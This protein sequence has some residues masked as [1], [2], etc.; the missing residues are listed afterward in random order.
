MNLVEFLQEHRVKYDTNHRKHGRPGWTQLEECPRCYSRNYHLG[1]KNDCSRANCYKCG[2]FN[3]ARLLLDVTKA[4]WSE[5]KFLVGGRIYIPP[6]LDTGNAGVYTEPR[7]VCDLDSTHIAYLKQ[8][9]LDP[10]YCTKVWGIRGLGPWAEYPFR[11]FLPIYYQNRPVSWTSRATHGQEPRYQTAAPHQKSLDEKRILYGIDFI[12]ETTIVLEGPFD[13]LRVGPGA[14]GTLG[15]S[16][17]RAQFSIIA[18]IPR[19]ILVFDNSERAQKIADTLA[20][21]LSLFPGETIRVNLDAEDPGS[22]SDSEIYALRKFAF[23]EHYA[24]ICHNT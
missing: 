5:V 4:P 11:V 18:S 17:T 6:T 8:R 9:G 21:E 1:I 16:V 7:G 13:V 2:G 22:A 15:T 20:Q 12:R 23:G 3:V 24:S 19:R 10:E 14:V